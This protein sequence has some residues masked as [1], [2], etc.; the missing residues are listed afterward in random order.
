MLVITWDFKL[1]SQYKIICYLQ[2]Y[3]AVYSILYYCRPRW[4]S[5]YRA[6]NWTQ[7][8]LVQ[9]PAEGGGFLRAVK[10]CSTTSSRGKI[11]PAIPCRK[12][13]RHVKD[14][15]SMKGTLVGKIHGHLS[16][17]S[18]AFATRCVYWLLPESSGAWFKDD[19]NSDGEAQYIGNGRSIWDA[20]CNTTP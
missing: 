17:D 4:C 10:I 15:Y 7:G 19:Y 14:P 6:C 20:L 12:I 13:L 3:N 1:S 5:G 16:Q 18:P 8:S 11:K 2:C 9:A